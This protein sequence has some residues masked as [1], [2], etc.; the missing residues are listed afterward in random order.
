LIGAIVRV[1]TPEEREYTRYLGEIEERQRRVAD[2]RTDL[3]LLKDKLGR[4]NA[5][6]HTR[7]G[8]LFIELDKVQLS[9]R[10]YE[11]RID[12]L[13]SDSD[14]D[15]NELE[16]ETRARFTEE[17]ESIHQDEEE[18]R[19]Y[20]RT[21]WEDQ[22]SPELDQLSE[23]RLKSL[24]RELAKRFH[25]DLARTNTERQ[26]R[27]TMMKC[28]NAAFHARDI[29]ALEGIGAETAFADPAFDARP[30]GEKLVWAIREVSRLDGLIASIIEERDGLLASELGEL[31]QRQEAG[32]NVIERLERV[33]KRDL[34]LAQQRLQ[35]V[36][37][38]FR[39]VGI[40]DSYER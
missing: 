3:Q 40:E 33:A 39:H 22:Q 19:E 10:E 1:Q 12:R 8:M 17:R 21:Y 37:D 4:F 5:E 11:H 30:I 18:T 23:A 7:V 28:V 13:R 15:P 14:V 29:G 36:I 32:E 2:L 35:E 20:E 16:G 6:Y 34:E 9:I 24:F 31:W 38:A 27:E 25:P 26:Q